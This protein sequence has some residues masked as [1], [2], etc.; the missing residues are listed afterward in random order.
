MARNDLAA[1]LGRPARVRHP[2][3]GDMIFLTSDCQ[4]CPHYLHGEDAT[5]FVARHRFPRDVRGAVLATRRFCLWGVAV[6]LL[7]TPEH[8]APRGCPKRREVSPLA[9]TGADLASNYA[10]GR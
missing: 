9:G 10:E 3:D 1:I 7:V 5:R 8:R 2:L 6:K 4:S